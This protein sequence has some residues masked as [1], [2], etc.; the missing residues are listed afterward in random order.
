[1]WRYLLLYLLHINGYYC[2]Y[3]C[4]VVSSATAALSAMSAALVPT[5][6]TVSTSIAAGRHVALRCDMSPLETS[7]AL[8]LVAV[9]SSDRKSVV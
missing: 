3:P 2:S 5:L 9:E 6:S 7:M 1:M 8:H 4:L